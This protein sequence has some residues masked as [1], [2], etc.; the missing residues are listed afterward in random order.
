MEALDENAQTVII[1]AYVVRNTIA[2]TLQDLVDSKDIAAYINRLQLFVGPE[3][4][5][6]GSEFRFTVGLY[7]NGFDG[8]VLTQ[9]P[10]SL[11]GPAGFYSLASRW[12]DNVSTS[13]A[14]LSDGQIN[15]IGVV[16]GMVAWDECD[17]GQLATTIRRTYVSDSLSPEQVFPLGADGACQP[18]Y[19]VADMTM[20]LVR[21][22]PSPLEYDNYIIP[23]DVLDA[24]AQVHIADSYI[25]LMTTLC[26]LQM[27][28]SSYSIVNYLIRGNLAIGPLGNCVG[29]VM[30]MTVALLQ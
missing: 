3:G 7:I 27:L 8:N 5:C 28:E 14:A 23:C 9:E 6:V 10:L 19:L 22:A 17:C 18:I 15:R 20:D 25:M 21:C 16:P 13:L 24:A 4:G 1:D 30:Q 11:R 2:C 26:M 29:S 12:A